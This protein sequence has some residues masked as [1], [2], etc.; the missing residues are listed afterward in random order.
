MC[1]PAAISDN[2]LEVLEDDLRI[3]I[4]FLL[5]LFFVRYSKKFSLVFYIFPDYQM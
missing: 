4:I 1:K 5:L 2:V 3:W